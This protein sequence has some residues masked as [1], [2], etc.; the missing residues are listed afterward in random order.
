MLKFVD[1]I[2]SGSTIKKIKKM[3]GLRWAEK[4]RNFNTK[5]YVP[6]WGQGRGWVDMFMM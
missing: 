6:K 5:I 2:D 3:F 4:T 1:D